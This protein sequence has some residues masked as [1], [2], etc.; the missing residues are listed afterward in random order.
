MSRDDLLPE[1]IED[2]NVADENS[3]NNKPFLYANLTRRDIRSLIFH[4]LYTAESLDYQDSLETI[5]HNYQRGFEVT[6]PQDSEVFVTVQSIIDKRE[7]LDNMYNTFLTN[8]KFE[9]VGMSAKL[10]LRFAIWEMLYTSTD[11]RIILNEAIELAKC[12][13]EDDAFRF[14]NGILDRIAQSR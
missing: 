14:I 6:I 11:S 7:E 3:D 1:N 5:I 4:L 8:W 10:V 9:R 12:F 2:T 13:A